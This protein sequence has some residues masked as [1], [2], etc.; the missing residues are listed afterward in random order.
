MNLEITE[1]IEQLTPDIRHILKVE[2][3]RDSNGRFEDAGG[4]FKWQRKTSSG[5]KEIK[6]PDNSWKRMEKWK[7]H[8]KSWLHITSITAEINLGQPLTAVYKVTVDEDI[9]S[10]IDVSLTGDFKLTIQNETNPNSSI[11]LK[12]NLTNG[13]GT[14]TIIPKAAGSYKFNN[15]A[16]KQTQMNGEV[17]FDVLDI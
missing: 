9:N 4:K 16:L 12:A 15:A 6:Q 3:M 13:E 14:L 7:S 10:A 8:L 1:E 17:I 5:F 2:T 11:R